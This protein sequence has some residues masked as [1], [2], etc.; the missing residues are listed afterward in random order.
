MMNRSAYTS[1]A[2]AAAGLLALTYGLDRA[3][4]QTDDTTGWAISALA[5][6][7]AVAGLAYWTTALVDEATHE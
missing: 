6:P 4:E 2:T 1:W 3:L 7:V 5:A